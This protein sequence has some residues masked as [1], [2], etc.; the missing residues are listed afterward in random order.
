MA[1]KRII[2]ILAMLLHIG[3]TST[4]APKLRSLGE[5]RAFCENPTPRKTPFE[6]TGKVL[7][8]MRSP[9]ACE[10]IVVDDSGTRVEFYRSLDLDQPFPGD[11]IRAEGMASMSKNH[12]PFPSIEEFEVFGHG[13]VPAPVDARLSEICVRSND[14][15]TIRTEG[16]VIDSF[17]DEIDRRYMI[18]L[19]KD[20]DA[21]VPVSLM[22]GEF[23]DVGGLV[24]ARVRITGVYRQSVSGIRKFSWP[25]IHPIPPDGI[26]VV[27]PPPDDPFAAPPL[28]SRLY[29][30]RDEIA[31]MSVR[32]AVG[33]VLA[34]WSGN[35]AMLRTDD[36]MIVNLRFA[37]GQPL[38]LCGER[39]LAV[40]LPETD[41]FRINLS[42]ARWRKDAGARRVSAAETPEP[43][44]EAIFWDDGG[45]RSIRGEAHGRLVCAGGIV[46]T[47]PS[48]VDADLRM[49]IDSGGVLI[50][51]DLTLA[52]DAASGV[53]IGCE[54]EVT[55]RCILLADS[56]WRDF[57]PAKV[58]GFMIVVRSPSDIRIL[59]RPSWW[60]PVRLA[61]LISVLLA[62]L[63]AIGIWNRTLRLLAERRG[64]ELSQEQVARAVSE[65]KKAERT[66]LAVELHDSLSQT[67]SG[68]AC[69]LAAGADMLNADATA[70]MG[71]FD[72]ARKMLGSCR[73]ELRQCL[74]D[75]R[76]DTLDEKDFPSAIRKALGQLEGDAAINVDFNVPR[77][78]FHDTTA[79]S[80]LAIVRELAGNAIRHGGATA[81]DIAASIDGKSLHF[82]VV[83][84]GCGF[85]PMNCE[86]PRQGHF[87]L[88]GVRNRIEK[89]GGTMEMRSRPGAGAR[90]DVTIPV[91]N[92][93]DAMKQGAPHGPQSC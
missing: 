82:S 90:A 39:I 80:I 5:V 35:C 13:P 83:D 2:S 9:K 61:A 15:R 66:R 53:P 81:V 41:L 12:E 26:E 50:P 67:L 86:G 3:A 18:L 28:E 16:A 89:L 19:L 47:I 76:S 51:V 84:N 23:G 91:P 78:L 22:R 27:E 65:Y 87:G 59:R 1:V 57:S 32:T 4:A 36:G 29:M 21:V 42:Y 33:E 55:G 30:T 74:F 25:N 88:E 92:R 77:G 20:G 49:V 56:G 10:I 7:A 73:R 64:R 79:H 14:L 48:Q 58:R 45:H 54:I 68:V 6:I 8:A 24:G 71:L 38:P 72:T 62:A 44:S 93:D 60:T 75:L 11:L 40:G 85:D 69:H 46:R 63:A 31:S 70:A 34:T 17:P 37:G 52:P 43:A